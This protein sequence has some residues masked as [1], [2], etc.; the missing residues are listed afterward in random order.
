V[1]PY[2][3]FKA[4]IECS[5]AERLFPYSRLWLGH[6]ARLH[7]KFGRAHVECLDS[8]APGHGLM[9]DRHSGHA[10]P[11]KVHGCFFSACGAGAHA[12]DALAEFCTGF[13]CRL[14][15]AF[16]RGAR[17]NYWPRCIPLNGRALAS[18]C[19]PKCTSFRTQLHVWADLN[20]RGGFEL[21]VENTAIRG[22]PIY[23]WTPSAESE[24][25]PQRANSSSN[26]PSRLAIQDS[27]SS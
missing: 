23:T 4:T 8:G 7:G 18:T 19:G 25:I 16:Y 5:I 21:V 20:S 10:G 27:A 13:A 17:G 12:C 6:R 11:P 24:A 1:T 22:G 2:L 14:Q 15:V 3:S 26:S 9:D